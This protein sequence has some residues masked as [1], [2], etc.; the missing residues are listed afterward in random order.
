[1]ANLVA[2]GDRI[3]VALSGLEKAEALHGDISFPRTAV[4]SARAV[5]EGMAEVHGMR[6][7]GSNVPGVVMVG[8]WREAG[9]VTFAVC[10]GQGP[11]VVLDLA[12]QHIDRVVVSVA[13]P[14]GE[15]AGLGLDSAVG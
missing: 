12:G 7:P 1:M 4:V 13:N 3:T 5:P 8:T 2:D 15:I 11:A 10:H 14:D 6:L 9:R